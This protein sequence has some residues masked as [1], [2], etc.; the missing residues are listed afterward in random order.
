[1]EQ[2]FRENPCVGCQYY[3]HL[4]NVTT[5]HSEN[6]IITGGAFICK[7]PELIDHVDEKR[8][9]PYYVNGE[10]VTDAIL[11]GQVFMNCARGRP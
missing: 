11:I 7:N 3:D 9:I 8:R 4:E 1:M 10:R 5:Y 2:P 6:R